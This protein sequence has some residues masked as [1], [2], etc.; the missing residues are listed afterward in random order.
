MNAAIAARRFFI[1]FPHF[2]RRI[3]AAFFV[4]DPGMLHVMGRW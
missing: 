1:L 4:Y 2:M 3:E